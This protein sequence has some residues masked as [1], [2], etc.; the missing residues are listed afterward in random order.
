MGGRGRCVS[1]DSRSICTC[2]SLCLLILAASHR[3]MPLEDL[4]EADFETSK[5]VTAVKSFDS[6]GLKHDLLRGVY[7]Y[8]FEKPSAIQ[9]RAVQ[10]IISGRDVIAQAQSG[11]GKTSMISLTMLQLLDT[12]LRE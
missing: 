5:D 7:N 9:Q 2:S 11:T 6:M 1:A 8:G 4:D 12:G 3:P 10:P